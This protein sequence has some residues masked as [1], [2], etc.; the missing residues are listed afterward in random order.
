MLAA[1][2]VPCP[3]DQ[4]FHSTRSFLGNEGSSETWRDLVSC[5]IEPTILCSLIFAELD[6][7]LCIN[8]GG[9]G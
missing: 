3:K 4:K 6:Q 8:E 7:V 9:K 2:S 1:E 5:K